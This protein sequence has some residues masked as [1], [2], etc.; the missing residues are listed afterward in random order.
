MI[1]LLTTPLDELTSDDLEALVNNA[2]PEG[3]QI[4]YKSTLPSRNGDDKWLEGQKEIGDYAKSSILEEVT[5]FANAHG[6]VLLV[7]IEDS[8]G[9]QGI[10]TG[11]KALPKCNELASRFKL[12]FSD[13]IEPSLP[14]LEIE[15]IETKDDCGVLFIRVGRSY[16]APHRVTS[17]LRCTVRRQDRCE[18]MSMREIQD[19][20]LNTTRGAKRLEK[21]IKKRAKRFSQEFERF[22]KPNQAFGIRVTGIP[23][24]ERDLLSQIFLNGQIDSSYSLPNVALGRQGATD[25]NMTYLL[26]S[27]T[28]IYRPVLRGA[29]TENSWYPQSKKLCYAEALND[30][31]IEIGFVSDSEKFNKYFVEPDWIVGLFGCGLG[32]IQKFRKN[33]SVVAMEYVVSVETYVQDN[34]V[35]FG[36]N[37]SMF[38]ENNR[39][40]KN[41]KFPKYLFG[42]DSTIEDLLVLFQRDLYNSVGWNVHAQLDDFYIE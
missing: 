33:S 18:R 37:R 14:I 12:I 1:D 34:E 8:P 22:D 42:L 24:N 30:G 6:G 23:T 5:A 13:G 39:H 2:V 9:N 11:I 3:E 36:H 20:T 38:P 15:A 31:L 29:R 35:N 7:G 32:W 41:T 28:R 4:E 16:D 17:T 19:L 10:P 26:E 25:R 40:L 27:L 21:R